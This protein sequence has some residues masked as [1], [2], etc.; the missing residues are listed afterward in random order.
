MTEQRDRIIERARQ[1]ATPSLPGGERDAVAWAE[2][3]C[4]LL[5]VVRG[6]GHP[7]VTSLRHY[8]DRSLLNEKTRHG[9]F[10]ATIR[11]VATGL[12]SDLETGLLPDLAIR[13]RGELE[14]SLLGQAQ[15]LLE[16]GLKDPAAMLVGAVLE[17]ALRQL[18]AKHAVPEGNNIEATANAL[19]VSSKRRSPH[20]AHSLSASMRT[21]GASP[22]RGW[23]ML[24]RQFPRYSLSIP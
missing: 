17:D 5:E 16:E 14:G 19:G 13:I 2:N 23:L 4:T 18:C 10:H 22:A 12:L 21:A 15:R 11:G 8:I 6:L 3:V 7:V 24:P 1:L 20:H 9:T